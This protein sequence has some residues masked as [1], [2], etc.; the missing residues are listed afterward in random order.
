M[1]RE[2]RYTRKRRTAAAVIA[3][4]LVAAMVLGI[5]APF[6]GGFLGA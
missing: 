1:K 5:I 4:I 3:F 2:N 6:L